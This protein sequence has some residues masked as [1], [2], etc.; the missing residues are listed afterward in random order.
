MRGPPRTYLEALELRL[1]TTQELLRNLSTSAGVDL[2]SL[3]HH[4]SEPDSSEK[5]Q[6]AIKALQ[7]N[8]ADRNNAPFG[9][10]PPQHFHPPGRRIEGIFEGVSPSAST[11]PLYRRML[12]SR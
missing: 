10:P 2:V 1:E 11:E 5:L 4:P 3:A 7:Q 12:T 9:L 8:E 6:K